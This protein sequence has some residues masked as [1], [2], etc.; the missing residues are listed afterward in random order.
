MSR[1]I[2]N[3]GT[4][5]NVY[6]N[7]DAIEA[8]LPV[9]ALQPSQS[10]PIT[11]SLKG[12][13][14]FTGQAGKVIKVNSS[15]NALEYADDSD[16]Q[17]W[18][19]N[20]GNLYPTLTATDVVIGGTSNTNNR[21][22][23]VNGDGEI[24]GQLTLG[25]NISNGTYTYTLPSS[26]GILA[27][28]S[29]LTGYITAS[30]TNT[31]TNKT[32]DGTNCKVSTAQFIMEAGAG[33]KNT[34]SQGYIDFFEAPSNG[35]NKITLQGIAS[36]AGDTV[37]NLPGSNGTIALTTDI[38]TTTETNFG[39]AATSDVSVGNSAGTAAS[40]GLKLYGDEFLLYNTS[41]VN[42]A[43][44]TPVSNTCNMTL[45]GGL[46]TTATLSTNTVWQGNTIGTIYG[47]TGLTS[48]TTG[49]ILY[50]SG[51]NTLAKLAIGTTG[52]VLKVSGGVP[53]WGTDG[54]ADWTVSG[55]NIYPTT[56]SQ[57]L[58]N[59]TTNA[60]DRNL[61]V[62]G[63]GEIQGNLS[64]SSTTSELEINSNSSTGIYFN[65]A[66]SSGFKFFADNG[67][68]GCPVVNALSTNSG[69][70]MEL[71]QA[72]TKYYRFT[73]GSQQLFSNN[74]GPD[75]ATLY[76]IK[77]SNILYGNYIENDFTN[78][79]FKLRNYG[80]SYDDDFMLVNLSTTNR[81]TTTFNK[82]A[83]FKISAGS[84]SNGDCTLVI[85]ADTD[86]SVE[87]SN[88]IIHLRQDGG[89]VNAY[90]Q[91]SDN[92]LS[93]GG[94]YPGENTTIY[95]NAGTINMSSDSGSSGNVATLNAT[96]TDIKSTSTKV[97]K[98]QT[99]TIEATNQSN[100]ILTSD[101]TYGWV[102][103]SNNPEFMFWLRRAGD[104]GTSI[105][106]ILGNLTGGF[107]IHMN[108]VGDAFSIYTDR[109]AKFYNNLTV[110]GE[111]TSDDFVVGQNSEGVGG[112][113]KSGYVSGGVHAALMEINNGKFLI[114][115]AF[116]GRSASGNY[117]FT[118]LRTAT[119]ACFNDVNTE[120]VNNGT[121]RWNFRNFNGNRNNTPVTTYLDLTGGGAASWPGLNITSDDRLKTNE[122]DIA[123][124]TETLMK[125]RPQKYDKALFLDSEYEDQDEATG[126]SQ[127]TI[128]N[129]FGFIAQ[130]IYYEV[131][132][133]RDLVNVPH[134]ATV[135]D[136]VD[137][138]FTDI[139][140][141]PDYSNWGD[142]P[143]S[144]D[145][146]SFIAI[147]TKGF[148]EQQTIIQIQQEEI[149]TQQEEI[150]TLKEILTRNNLF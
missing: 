19:L 85:E 115:T 37:L 136:D 40:V 117:A 105:F 103:E 76:F 6:L 27:T 113:I 124:A 134:D 120:Y 137:R 36:L 110:S 74:G 49:D 34:I 17:Q 3:E 107:Q 31:L 144:V 97:V 100:N 121:A 135:V 109:T 92:E 69:W 94:T 21:K 127:N 16:T 64:L 119:Y 133:L 87:T 86:N 73:K 55:A 66:A 24:T 82:H 108:N 71:R 79:T 10:D 28:T 138:D 42:V 75:L 20:S 61:L 35:T 130:E 5:V 23:L 13:N 89:V 81:K 54:S 99:N 131:P 43:T 67:N 125:L 143:A 29:D 4:E 129:E 77:E 116:A 128:R 47:G 90:L 44:F 9:Q 32:L 150:N 52:Q 101:A 38:D 114:D 139:Q 68:F 65:N 141:D 62:N 33:L 26:T 78:S 148:Q 142:K 111:T 140:N 46:I 2:L 56:A 96:L 18:T 93:L 95:T 98:L 126:I 14:G 63:S 48:Y 11:V 106:P 1:N 80:V 83:E 84:G 25:S 12:L 88:P 51:T 112:D 7:R 53:A 41:N 72:G 104:T 122:Q 70:L 30:S 45:N 57:L 22:L 147:L 50:A 58:V 149:N 60:D 91:L 123:N 8:T 59:T 15:E 146:N 102:M 145:Y 118:H 39:T 132:E